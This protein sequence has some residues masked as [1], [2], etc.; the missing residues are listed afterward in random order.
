MHPAPKVPQDLVQ[1]NC[2]N[3][4]L[5]TRDSVL[6]WE[7]DKNGETAKVHVHGQWTFNSGSRILE[8][9]L[10]GCGIAY[11]PED[12]ARADIAAGKLVA[13]LQDWCEPFA[14]Y[15]LY[16]PNRKTSPVFALVVEALRRLV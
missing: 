8:A 9:A 1:H 5:P 11:L 16:Y 7:F 12:M 4:R 10:A 6:P 14:G 13:V 15:Y 2:I 3:L